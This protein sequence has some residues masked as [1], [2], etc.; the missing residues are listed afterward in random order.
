MKYALIIGVVLAVYWLWRSTRQVGTGNKKQTRA[1]QKPVVLEKATEIVACQI[2]H[3]H[4]PRN[5][6]LIGSNGLYCS[7]EHRQQ[8]GD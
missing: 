6:A 3:V 1:S 8:A 4:L 7:A 5:E 2:C